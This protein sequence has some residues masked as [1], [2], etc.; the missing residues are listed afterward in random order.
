[1]T[2][3]T[4]ATLTI[5]PTMDFPTATDPGIARLRYVLAG[6]ASV[7]E[8]GSSIGLMA[9]ALLAL[10]SLHRWRLRDSQV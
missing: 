3:I 2:P 5:E 9:I 1:M 6:V 4:S 7:P 8:G 10:F